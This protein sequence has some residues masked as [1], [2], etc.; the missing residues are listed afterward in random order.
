MKIASNGI[1]KMATLCR[2]SIQVIESYQYEEDSIDIPDDWVIK[3]NDNFE[4]VSVLERGKYYLTKKGW[5]ANQKEIR[6]AYEKTLKYHPYSTEENTWTAFVHY[7][8]SFLNIYENKKV[9]K[10]N[11]IKLK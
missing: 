7:V 6:N 5:K 11:N 1:I 3:L 2:I 4:E 9:Q 8:E 10:P